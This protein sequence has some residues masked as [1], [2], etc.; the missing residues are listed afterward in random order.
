MNTYQTSAMSYPPDPPTGRLRPD[1][2]ARCKWSNHLKA[3]SGYSHMFT[4]DL[5]NEMLNILYRKLDKVMEGR[6]S[7]PSGHSSTAFC[8]MVFLSLC[9]AGL[10]GAWCLSQPAPPRSFLGSRIARISLTLLPVGFATW[11]AISRLEDYVCSVSISF[12]GY[13]S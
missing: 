1:F 7:F 5:T 11:V 9:L 2:L 12:Q 6:R 13:H 8:G 4:N 3:C 10:T